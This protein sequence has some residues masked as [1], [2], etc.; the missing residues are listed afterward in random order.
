MTKLK[1]MVKT[2]IIFL[3]VMITICFVFSLYKV[4]INEIQPTEIFN[5]TGLYFLYA[6]GY[7]ALEG[8]SAIQSI[9]AMV[10]IVSLALMT[11]F[12]TIDYLD[13]VKL[14]KE[15]IYK[16]NFLK[17][18][19]INKGKAICDIKVAFALYD[20]YT[21]ENI[22]DPKEYYM[23]IL[24]KNS[25]WNL[26]LDL[27]ETFGYKAVYY[28]L[29]TNDKKLYCTFSF[30]DTQTGQNSIKVEEITKNNIKVA[31]RL[32]EF[33]EFIQPT[34]LPCKNLMPIENNGHIQIENKDDT[35]S[36]NYSFNGKANYDSF[37]MAYYNFHEFPLNLEKYNK[38]TTYLE[39][40]IKSKDDIK[41]KFDLIL[42]NYSITAKN[43]EINSEAKT[44]RINL[45]DILDNIE[46]VKEIRYTIFGKNNASEGRLEIGDLRII[47]K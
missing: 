39:F 32:L 46:Q 3:I 27:N 34:I 33:K 8:D 21:S 18:Q 30:V 47:T 20:K 45:K 15:I 5:E 43:I 9:L 16:N 38:E 7:G 11:T 19:F 42:L 2:V 4:F 23:P 37:V 12:L 13:D 25:T 40:M 17:M 28:L 6:I 22:V 14:N 35:V 36:I 29:S 41:L 24:P 26:L 1:K 44:I 10:G 31:N